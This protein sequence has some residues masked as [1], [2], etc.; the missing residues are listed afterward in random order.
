MK[1]RIEILG[2]NLST[3][4]V[5]I[6]NTADLLYLTGLHLSCGVLGVTPQ[7]SVLFVDGRYFAK[8]ERES[9][10]GVRLLNKAAVA[11]WLES[12]GVKTLE[13]D[14]AYTSYDRYLILKDELKG[15][16]LRAGSS[17]LKDMRAVKE[18]DEIEALKRAADL[19][20][21]G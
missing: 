1:T 20:W 18:K 13:F 17:L 6:E 2:K 5:L 16:E 21:R 4:A 12:R 15:M 11:K 3:D 9:G 14:S 19:T 10:L 8:A 7:E